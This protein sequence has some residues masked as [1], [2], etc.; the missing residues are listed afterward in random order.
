MEEAFGQ[1]V[2][3]FVTTLAFYNGVWIYNFP[4]SRFKYSPEPS[5]ATGLLSYDEIL[6]QERS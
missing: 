6:I 5:K 2:C 4:R 3:I 1:I